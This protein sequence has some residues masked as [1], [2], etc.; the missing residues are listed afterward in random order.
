MQQLHGHSITYRIAIGPTKAA[1]CSPKAPTVGTLQSL[2]PLE[3]PK[4]GSSRVAKVAG[5][6]LHAGVAAE[7]HQRDKL[8]RL[9][10]YIARPAVSEKRLSLL[11]DGR[12]R[13]E[14]KTFYRDGTTD[15]AALAH[16]VPAALVRPCT[17]SSSRWTFWP[18][19]LR[20]FPNRG[21]TSPDSTG[22]LRLTASIRYWSR[23]PNEAKAASATLMK[24]GN[25]NHRQ[26][27]GHR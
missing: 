14:L 3:E 9:C 22:C 7:A 27:A 23:L 11:D 25:P 21:S 6:S 5:F 18:G 16:P 10:R 26:S 12:I 13:Y 19:L 1:R 24:R 2:P 4:A 17:S 15:V 20:W 8:E